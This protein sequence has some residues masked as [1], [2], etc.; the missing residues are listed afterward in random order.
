MPVVYTFSQKPNY[1][2]GSEA[3]WSQKSMGCVFIQAFLM[4][5]DQTHVGQIDPHN[6]NQQA[7]AEDRWNLSST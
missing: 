5:L 1:A 2:H 7:E 4:K 6:P 3:N